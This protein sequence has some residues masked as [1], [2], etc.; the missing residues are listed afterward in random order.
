MLLPSTPLQT[1]DTPASPSLKTVSL[2][3]L[4]R[5]L[6]GLSKVSIKATVSPTLLPAEPAI[7]VVVTPGKGVVTSTGAEVSS[8]KLNAPL[9]AL[10]LPASSVITAVRLFAPSAPRSAFVK[11]KSTRPC[12][13]WVS[14]SVTTLAVPKGCPPSRSS[15]LSPTAANEPD[16]GSVTRKLVLWASFALRRPSARSVLPCSASTGAA[17]AVTSSVKTRAALGVP[18]LPARSVI[19]AVRLLLPSAPRSAATTV[20]ST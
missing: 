3:P 5:P 18:T 6:T 15:T 11:V 7:E 1:A 4:V 20:K 13:R 8:V 12:D 17:G 19:N 16:V 2:L 14:F 9:G 10:A